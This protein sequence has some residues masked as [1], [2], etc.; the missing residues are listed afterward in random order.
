MLPSKAASTSGFLQPVKG[1]AGSRKRSNGRIG[2]R[3]LPGST[4]MESSGSP[5]HPTATLAEVSPPRCRCL[6][7]CHRID[8]P[9]LSRTRP[10]NCRGLRATDTRQ[11]AVLSAL[12]LSTCCKHSSTPVPKLSP[13]GLGRDARCPQTRTVQCSSGLMGGKGKFSG[14]TTWIS[15]PRNYG[16]VD[17]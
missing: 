6:I 17:P 16:L 9:R 8:L 10:C 1:A 12:C 2:A 7:S 14:D 15:Y 13:S 4:G 5:L 11:T 3:R